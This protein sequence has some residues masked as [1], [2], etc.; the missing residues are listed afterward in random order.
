M[1]VDAFANFPEPPA[2]M[3][4]RVR[5]RRGALL[6]TGF[7]TISTAWH[8][9]EKSLHLLF[10]A[11]FFSLGIVGSLYSITRI[12]FFHEPIYNENMEAF[13]PRWAVL[14]FIVP[15][16][17]VLAVAF[18]FATGWIIVQ[19]F[20]MTPDRPD[21]E[22]RLSEDK[23]RITRFR[24][25]THPD[26]AIEIQQ[27]D[28]SHFTLLGVDRDGRVYAQGVTGS[29]GKEGVTRVDLTR[30]LLPEEAAWVEQAL[31]PLL[32]IASSSA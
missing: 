12:V 21:W 2:W 29:S 23:W 19:A 7:H 14:T 26:D 28:P 24:K 10:L 31:R 16:I 9:I 18:G 4:L 5:R 25:H 11:P 8:Y 13:M 22:L 1:Q 30:S 17:A 3:K 20:Q 6:L 15:L 32:T 27:I